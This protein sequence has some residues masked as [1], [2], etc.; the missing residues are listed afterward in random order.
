[1]L[2][3]IDEIFM[4]AAVEVS[5][6]ALG[7][8]Q[9]N[10]AVGAILVWHRAK[11]GSDNVIIGRGATAPKGRPHAETIALA[12]AANNHYGTETL[13]ATT[14]Y[15]T[16]EPCAHYGQTPPCATAL[17]KSG[18]KR[19]VIA[20][21]DIDSRV[22][23]QGIA[24]LRSA[25]IEV[26]TGVQ[27]DF[28]YN[29]LSRYFINKQYHRCEVTLKLALTNDAA[30]GQHG[31]PQVNITNALSKKISHKL[32]SKYDAILIG[33]QTALVD[34]PILSCRLPG[35]EKRSPVRIVLDSSLQLALESN[36]VKTAHIQPLWLV[37]SPM[38][39]RARKE[40]LSQAGVKILELA[41]NSDGKVNLPALLSHLYS[42]NIFAL[43][44]EG[45]AKVAGSFLNH[46][47]VDRLALFKSPFSIAPSI[48]GSIA[49]EI[50]GGRVLAPD[51]NSIICSNNY[52]LIEQMA[53]NSDH[54]QHWL[55][56]NKCLQA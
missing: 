50:A 32:R 17:I 12:Q 4:K 29:I 27:S 19:V 23:R 11:N 10:P 1:M 25:G 20:L 16:L 43:L 47:L 13:A 49:S 21:C 26:I 39:P 14:A 55:R 5:S 15:V 46:N 8:T 54:Y 37:C 33:S 3:N 28:A 35:L 44:V 34:N 7:T 2:C 42:L 9:E 40:L 56:I 41:P 48:A 51:L 18:I 52:R 38:A 30:I 6:A 45:G 36:L 22:A 31:K 24:M 53:L